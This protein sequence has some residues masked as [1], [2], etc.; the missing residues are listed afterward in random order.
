MAISYGLDGPKAMA[1]A[2]ADGQLVNTPALPYISM[3]GR[4]A[5]RRSSYWFGVLGSRMV[6]WQ[7]RMPVFNRESQSRGESEFLLRLVG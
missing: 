3:E 5:V 6:S 7:I 2:E 4:G 1:K